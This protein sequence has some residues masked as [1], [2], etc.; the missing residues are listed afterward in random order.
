MGLLLEV[1]PFVLF[2]VLF[3]LPFFLFVYFNI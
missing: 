1:D 3:C 2:I